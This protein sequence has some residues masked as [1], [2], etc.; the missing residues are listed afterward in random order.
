MGNRHRRTMSPASRNRKVS[1]K[2]M[3]AART[4]TL[5]R[6]ARVLSGE[7]ENVGTPVKKV[8]LC[9]H[10]RAATDGSTVW[11]PAHMNDDARIN[12]MMQEAV[13]AHE[14]AGHLRYTDF[15]AWKRIGDKIKAGEEDRLL[16]DFVNILED[17]RVNHLLA[18]DF[19]GSG[20]RL[21]ATHDIFMARHRADW[22]GKVIT[23]DIAGRAAIIA[24]MTECINHEPH[25]FQDS[26]KVCDYMDEVRSLLAGAVSQPNTSSVVKA[27]KVILTTFRKHFPQSSSDDDM[28]GVPQSEDGEGMSMDDM[29]PEAIERMANEQKKREAKPEEVSRSRFNDLK[30]E[31]E[32]MAKKAKEAKEAAENDDDAENDAGEG[33]EGDETSEGGQGAS[34]GSEGEEGDESALNGDSAD[35]MGDTAGEGEGEGSDADAEGEGGEGEGDSAGEGDGEGEGGSDDGAPAD[36]EGAPADADGGDSDDEGDHGSDEAGDRTNDNDESDNSKGRG[37][38][39]FDI[40]NLF[41]ELQDLMENEVIEAMKNDARDEAEAE[42]SID[43]DING[44]SYQDPEDDHSQIN[45]HHAIDRIRAYE[46]VGLYEDQY[47]AVV[48]ANKAQI[49]TMQNQMKRLLKDP[50]GKFQRALKKGRVDSR[51]LAYSQTSNRVFRKRN[52]ESD[53]RVNVVVLIDASGSMGGHRAQMASEAGVVLTEVMDSVGWNVEVVDFNS[54]WSD[55]DIRVRKPMNAPVNQFTKAAIAM[56][57]SGSSN[58]DGYAVQWCLDRVMT[59]TGKKIVFVISDGQPSGAHPHNMTEEEHLR[60]VVGNAPKEVGLFSIGIDGMDTSTYYPHS[61]SCDSSDLAKAVLPVFKQMVRA[62]R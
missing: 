8:V 42:S 39:D 37:G 48:K 16:H 54:S 4:R 10:G 45:V 1:E 58:G 36:G 7:L 11:V 15:G 55:T 41:D 62:M 26:E 38:D 47:N 61:A 27:A 28:T 18:Q 46:R 21:D 34:E 43:A 49:T 32:K 9:P 29:S 19:A 12:L 60:H 24:M 51:R 3:T 14:A 31:M 40:E 2:A 56:P 13:L 25:F 33:A 22:A 30:D 23:D 57:F 59:F 50:Q 5:N 17:A 6:V 20:K 53:A 44:T 52:E 35:E